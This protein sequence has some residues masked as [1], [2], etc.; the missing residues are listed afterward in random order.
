METL[1]LG[2]RVGHES[3]PVWEFLPVHPNAIAERT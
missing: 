1:L 3:V 2:H